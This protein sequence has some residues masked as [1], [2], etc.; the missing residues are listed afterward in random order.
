MPDRM[1]WPALTAGN[2]A[3]VERVKVEAAVLAGIGRF[4]AAHPWSHNG[5]YHR[6]LLRVLRAGWVCGSRSA[7]SWRCPVTAGTTW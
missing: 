5:A 7:T 4:N 1:G 2:L 3:A 6:W